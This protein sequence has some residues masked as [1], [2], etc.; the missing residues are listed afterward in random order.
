MRCPT[1]VMGLGLALCLILLAACATRPTHLAHKPTPDPLPTATASMQL[2]EK[3]TPVRPTP[4][5][6][7]LRCPTWSTTVMVF[8]DKNE[9]GR[10][11]KGDERVLPGVTV[12]G[13][14]VCQSRPKEMRQTTSSDGRAFFA[15]E[16]P[17]CRPHACW[18]L[19]IETPEGYRVTTHEHIPAGN[20]ELITWVVGVAPLT[21]EAKPITA[22]P[23][24]STTAKRD[25]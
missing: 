12:W 25:Y 2:V 13:D 19:Y 16:I 8:V 7:V 10:W 6:D 11:Q 9:D 24:P 3:P 5:Q 20:S 18:S 14:N 17:D 15:G 23:Q 1:F 22:T 4:T 21:P